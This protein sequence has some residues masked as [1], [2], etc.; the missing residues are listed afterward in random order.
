MTAIRTFD[1]GATRDADDS[2]LDYEGFLSPLVLERYARYMHEHRRQADGQLRDSDNWTKGIPRTA[3]AKSLWRHLMDVMFHHRGLAQ[4]A[5]D[6]LQVALCAVIFNAMGMLHE[7]LLGRDVGAPSTADC[8][9]ADGH[10]ARAGVV[11]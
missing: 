1:T 8:L 2:K 7:V 5:R 4:L 11:R 6:P 3:Y 10:A 9:L